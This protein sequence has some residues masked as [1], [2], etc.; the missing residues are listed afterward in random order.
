M[1]SLHRSQERRRRRESRVAAERPRGYF[2]A[3][4]QRGTGGGDDGAGRDRRPTAGSDHRGA[5]GAACP[6]IRLRTCWVYPQVL[7]TDST[8]QAWSSCVKGWEFHGTEFHIGDDLSAW[9]MRSSNWHRYRQDWMSPRRCFEPDRH[10]FVDRVL[11]SGS[12]RRRRP[13]WHSRP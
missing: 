10:R 7:H 2:L 12:G 11:R 3:V 5:F 6:S 1:I 4:V 9:S 8:R 13:C